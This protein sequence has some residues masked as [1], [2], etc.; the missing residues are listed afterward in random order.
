MIYYK[1]FERSPKHEWVI[2]IHG[3]GGSSTIWFKQIK[4]LR[5]H[6]NILLVELRG[7]GK[8]T[9][10]KTEENHYN[11]TMT[12]NDVVEV[13]DHLNIKHAHFIGISLGSII[14]RNIAKHSPKRVKSMILGGL[15]LGFNFRSKFLIF[16]GNL[17][18]KV[19]PYMWLYNLFAWIMMPNKNHKES[20]ELFGKEAKKMNQREFIKWFRITGDVDSNHKAIKDPKLTIPTLCIMGEEDYMFL[21]LVQKEVNKSFQGEIIVFEN[22]GHVC[23]IEEPDKFNEVSLNFIYKHS[24]HKIKEF[25]LKKSI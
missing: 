9:G 23:N 22:T 4:E 6:F 25:D 8:S 14:I 2:M 3:L 19:I 16:L 24:N 13:L 11:F 5:K 21:P 1:T 17:V 7:H 10:E 12:S 18:K 15:I 20:R